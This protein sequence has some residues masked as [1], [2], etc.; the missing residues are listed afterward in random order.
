LRVPAGGVVTVLT[1][2]SPTDEK[3]P[4]FD[5]TARTASME[6]F[7]HDD[8]Y[9]VRLQLALSNLARRVHG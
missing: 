6:Y 9:L 3:V 1:R 7:T 4:L 8:L 5:P 2:S